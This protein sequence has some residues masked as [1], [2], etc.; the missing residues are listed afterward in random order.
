MKRLNATTVAEPQDQMVIDGPD[1]NNSLS[2]PIPA[3]FNGNLTFAI[4]ADGS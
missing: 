2:T 1:T 4:A 3:T